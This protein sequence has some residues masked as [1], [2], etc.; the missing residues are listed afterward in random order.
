MCGIAGVV[1]PPGTRPDVCA[2]ERM[3][4]SLDHRGPDGHGSIIID[5]VGLGHTRLAIVDPTPAGDQP[6]AHP[7]GRWW[8]VYNGEIYNHLALRSSLPPTPYRS[9]TDTETLLHGL[10]TWGIDVVRRCNGLFAF[11]ALDV[12]SRRLWLVRDRWGVKPL[13]VARLGTSL[14]FASELG[15]LLA[16]GV[17]RQAATDALSHAL[18]LGWTNGPATPLSSV[19]RVGAGTAVAIDLDTLAIDAQPWFEPTELVDASVAAHLASAGRQATTAMVEEAVRLSVQRRLMADVPIGTMCSGG[20]DSSLVTAFAKD[21]HRSV[22]A[23][24]ASIS[25]DPNQDERPWAEAVA[26]HL[27]VD[28]HV[29]CC[30]GDD[31]RQGLVEAVAHYEYPL[32]HEA[33]V[34]LALVAEAGAPPRREGVAQWGG[35]RRAVRRLSLAPSIRLGGVLRP[36]QPGPPRRVAACADVS[37]GRGSSPIGIRSPAAVPAPRPTSTRGPRFARPRR[38]RAPPGPT[39]PARGQAAVGAQDLPSAGSRPPGQEHHAALRRDEAAV[40]RP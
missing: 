23:F 1:A 5:N 35:R 20:I 40:P 37:A 39:S 33:S 8:L 34:P 36:Q 18:E 22:T 3:T 9:G 14:A 32:T 38:V 7:D 30:T 15:A 26:Q 21:E 10:H 29:A 13:Y 16:G 12:V 4:L 2:L 31:W 25:D 24:C 28:L 6:M 17:P 11:A 27:D 19:E